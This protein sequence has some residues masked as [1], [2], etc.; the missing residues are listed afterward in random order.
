MALW[1]VGVLLAPLGNALAAI[2][3]PMPSCCLCVC[4][5]VPASSVDGKLVGG[6]R[7]VSDGQ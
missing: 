1:N 2:Q 7:I 5:C 6:R 3:S 4:A